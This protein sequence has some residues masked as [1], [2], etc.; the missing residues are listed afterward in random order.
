[1]HLMDVSKEAAKKSF[2]SVPAGE[3]GFILNGDVKDMALIRM[4]MEKK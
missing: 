1:M 3:S 4:Q 2:T